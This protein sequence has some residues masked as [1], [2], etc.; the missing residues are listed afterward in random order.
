AGSWRL[1]ARALEGC[2]RLFGLL[3]CTLRWL[4]L[5]SEAERGAGCPDRGTLDR[6]P[7]L[8]GREVG[9]LDHLGEREDGADGDAPDLL[10][11]AQEPIAGPVA[12]RLRHHG[13]H[14]VISLHAF[15]VGRPLRVVRELWFPE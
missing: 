7:E 1:L 11:L 5:A 3:W 8:A 4:W 15:N 13:V 12:E 2:R 6:S 14:A 9:I 10:S